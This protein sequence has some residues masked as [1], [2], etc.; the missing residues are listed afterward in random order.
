MTF[1]QNIEIMYDSK[2]QIGTGPHATE[3]LRTIVILPGVTPPL[4]YS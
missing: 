4:K 2:P 1:R 3:P